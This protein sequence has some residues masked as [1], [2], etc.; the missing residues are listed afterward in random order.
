VWVTVAVTVGRCAVLVTTSG[1]EDAVTTTVTVDDGGRVTV[2]AA[3]GVAGS[4]VPGAVVVAGGPAEP[5]SA[6][7]VSDAIGFD[8]VT[9][10]EAE[11]GAGKAEEAVRAAVVN[12]CAAVPPTSDEQPTRSSAATARSGTSDQG[13]TAPLRR[14]APVRSAHPDLDLSALMITRR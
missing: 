8:S 2:G 4:D 13:R 10:A 11:V 9:W 5:A 3:V 12:C 14:S 6:L 7:L 1:E